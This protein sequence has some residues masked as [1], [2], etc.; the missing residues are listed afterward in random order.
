MV[1]YVTGIQRLCIGGYLLDVLPGRAP[2]NA[3]ANPDDL[4][5]VRTRLTSKKQKIVEVKTDSVTS[6]PS[7]QIHRQVCI[8]S[9]SQER[10]KKE[11]QSRIDKIQTD[12]RIA[13]DDVKCRTK[14]QQALKANVTLLT[15]QVQALKDASATTKAKLRGDNSALQ[16]ELQ[17]GRSTIE[18]YKVLLQSEMTKAAGLDDQLSSLRNEFENHKIIAERA[19]KAHAMLRVEFNQVKT[20]L[21]MLKITWK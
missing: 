19:D 21:R 17:N 4:R 12:L 18:R 10:V 9:R 16:E 7:R 5:T 11:A 20:E 2:A 1:K 15:G 13:V 3:H 8:E 14:D 6:G